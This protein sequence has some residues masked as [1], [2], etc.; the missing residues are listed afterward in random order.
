MLLVHNRFL[1][2]LAVNLLKC[3]IIILPVSYDLSMNRNLGLS[4]W[5]NHP[6]IETTLHK[7]CPCYISVN[8]LKFAFAQVE[9]G[10]N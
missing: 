4:W 1:I 2:L 5:T 10:T 6:R 3:F 7:A 9:L 8:M